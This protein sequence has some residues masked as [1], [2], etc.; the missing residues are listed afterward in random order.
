MFSTNSP[1][2]LLAEQR[3][4][5]FPLYAVYGSSVNSLKPPSSFR[6]KLGNIPV[7]LSR[8]RVGPALRGKAGDSAILE[9]ITRALLGK[10]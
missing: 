9:S 6:Q 3:R 2:C 10:C 8:G 7:E 5:T 4:S 1:G